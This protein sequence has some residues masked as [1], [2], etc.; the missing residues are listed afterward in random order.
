VEII[1]HWKLFEHQFTQEHGHGPSL[2]QV[3]A[4]LNLGRSGAATLERAMISVQN[5]SRPVSLDVLCSTT[6]QVDDV[7]AGALPESPADA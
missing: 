6:G 5:F 4:G 2:E 3:A 1:A 7:R